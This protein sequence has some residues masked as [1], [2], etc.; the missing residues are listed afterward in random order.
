MAGFTYYLLTNPEK[1]ALLTQELRTTFTT[2]ADITMESTSSLKYLNA[3][4]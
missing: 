4:M 1:L 3:C 2:E